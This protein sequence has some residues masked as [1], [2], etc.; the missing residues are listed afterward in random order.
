MRKGMLPK[1]VKLLL[2]DTLLRAVTV[3]DAAFGTLQAWN[4][5]VEGL[6]IATHVGFDDSFL[7]FFDVVRA[8]DDCACGRALRLRKR[9]IVSDIAEDPYFAPYLETAARAGFRAVQSTPMVGAGGHVVG[10]LSTHFANP[11]RLAR[12][13]AEALDQLAAE[14][15]QLIERSLA[16][17]NASLLMHRRASQV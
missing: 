8:E 17:S 9:V 1:S 15:G 2:H 11:R 10:V 14:A 16:L 4:P 7:K 5:N 12:D 13:V 6:E 3:S